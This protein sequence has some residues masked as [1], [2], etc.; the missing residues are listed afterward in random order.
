MIRRRIGT[1]RVTYNYLITVLNLLIAS[2]LI[3]F[4]IDLPWQFK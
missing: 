3:W 1:W 2:G 4:M